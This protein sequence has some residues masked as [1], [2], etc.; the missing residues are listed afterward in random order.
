MEKLKLEKPGKFTWDY[1]AEADVLYVSFGQP[2]P[3]LALELG[4]GFLAR[5]RESDAEMVGF[6][7]LDASRLLKEPAKTNTA[8]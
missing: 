7:I 1:D 6:T 3:A 8:S 5:Y 4:D 2:Q